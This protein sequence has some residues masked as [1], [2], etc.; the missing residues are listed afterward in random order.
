MVMAA[1]Q[2]GKNISD[3]LINPVAVTF[4]I[5]EEKIADTALARRI[6][7]IHTEAAL[8]ASQNVVTWAEEFAAETGKKLMVML[9]AAATSQST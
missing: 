2:G 4:G 5:P 3:E 8:F 7:K 9:S 6:R 1:R